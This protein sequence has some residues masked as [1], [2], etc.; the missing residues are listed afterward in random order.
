MANYREYGFSA[1][2]TKPYRLQ[3]MSKVLQGLL[4]L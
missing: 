3:E 1:V 2:L 4:T